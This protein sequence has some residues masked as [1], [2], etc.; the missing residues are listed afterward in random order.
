[1]LNLTGTNLVV[2]LVPA[3]SNGTAL[4]ITEWPFVKSLDGLRGRAYLLGQGG[5]I[6]GISKMGTICEFWQ[7]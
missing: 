6:Y 7:S 3:P 2:V 4:L 1:M 5:N